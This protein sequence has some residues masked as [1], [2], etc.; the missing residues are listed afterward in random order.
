MKLIRA[1]CS[2]SDH[3][4]GRNPVSSGTESVPREGTGHWSGQITLCKSE[5]H[6]RDS[7]LESSAS[8]FTPTQVFYNGLGRH[9]S[10]LSIPPFPSAVMSE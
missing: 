9:P 10:S 8:I 6:K 4:D 1:G 7:P 5:C 3:V 2:G